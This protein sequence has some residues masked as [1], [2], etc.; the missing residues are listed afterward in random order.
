MAKY[1]REHG[2]TLVTFGLFILF[3]I[4]MGLVG[5]A[6]YAQQ[7]L[8][9]GLA[10]VAFWAYFTTGHF[11]EATFENWESEYLQMGLF[12]LLTA[13]LVQK[14]SA[15]SKSEEEHTKEQ[16]EET[17]EQQ[18]KIS[19]ES[20]G[21]TPWPIR[22]GG[23]IERLYENSLSIAL[24]GLFVLCFIFHAVYGVRE[25]N[26]EQSYLGQPAITVWQFL[27]TATF[28]FQ[29]LQNWQS[30]FLAVGSMVVLT[31]YLRQKGSAESKRV[32]APSRETGGK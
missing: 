11:W 23:W 31:I 13:Y 21:P 1:W 10:P 6:D 14:G 29:S 8:D 3:W 15:E 24:L 27:G 12:V 28:W 20:A 30:E 26:L 4:G 18:G 22:R 25:Y 19:N 32:G 2:L 17:D 16:E 7:Q 9:H 5:F